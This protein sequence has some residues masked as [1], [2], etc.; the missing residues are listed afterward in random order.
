[1]VK[2]DVNVENKDN[3]A[4]AKDGCWKTGDHTYIKIDEINDEIHLKKLISIVQRRERENLQKVSNYLKLQGYYYKHLLK[5]IV[6]LKL[7]VDL[8]FQPLSFTFNVEELINLRK[9]IDSYIINNEK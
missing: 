2:Q 7:S 8:K 4:L 3:L 9:E 1:M 5:R 6:D